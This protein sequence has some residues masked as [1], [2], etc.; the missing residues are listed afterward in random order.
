MGWQSKRKK[1]SRDLLGVV[2]SQR[3]EPGLITEDEDT[4]ETWRGAEP[5]TF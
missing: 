5:S 2:E 4:S 3:Q 1:L